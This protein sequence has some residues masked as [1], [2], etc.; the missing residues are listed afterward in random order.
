MVSENEK[1]DSKNEETD[2]WPDHQGESTEDW[3]KKEKDREQDYE[4]SKEEVPSP[5]AVA[6]MLQ[7]EGIADNIH[8]AE[9]QCKG[10]VKGQDISWKSR[11]KQEHQ[12]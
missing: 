2:R 6:Q 12:T 8:T 3:V 7:R 9:E 5:T 10:N 11:I 4:D 1:G